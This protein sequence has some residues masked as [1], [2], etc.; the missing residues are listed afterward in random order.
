MTLVL[1]AG[2]EL[3]VVTGL[4][5]L[6]RRAVGAAPGGGFRAV[7][8]MTVAVLVVGTVLPWSGVVLAVPVIAGITIVVWRSRW[9][10]G[11]LATLLLIAGAGAALGYQLAATLDPDTGSYGDQSALM[12]GVAGGATTVVAVAFGAWRP[13]VRSVQR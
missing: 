1:L 9:R 3:L 6:R 8:A 11:D 5:L 7:A 13:R 2:G 10:A 4:V 12:L